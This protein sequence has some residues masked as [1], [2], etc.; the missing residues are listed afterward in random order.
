MPSASAKVAKVTQRQYKFL[1]KQLEFRRLPRWRTLRIGRWSM[2]MLAVVGG[3]WST[4]YLLFRWWP[5]AEVRKAREKNEHYLQELHLLTGQRDTLKTLTLQVETMEKRMYASL[6]P[7]SDS[8]Q[9]S[10]PPLL[11]HNFA[12][13]L[14]ED[15]LKAYLSRAEA[16]LVGLLRAQGVLHSAELRSPRLPRKLPCACE[17]LGAGFG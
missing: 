4:A 2:F 11:P 16:A 6:V 15:T 8:H 14:S 9:R 13:P 10:S 3:A 7:S 5:S 12:P 1:P 17:E